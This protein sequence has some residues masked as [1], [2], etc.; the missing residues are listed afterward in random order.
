MAIWFV[1]IPMVETT[2]YVGQSDDEQGTH[3]GVS[4]HLGLDW[5]L[6]LA[7][8]TLELGLFLLDHGVARTSFRGLL[9]SR[10]TYLVE[11]RQLQWSRRGRWEEPRASHLVA[12]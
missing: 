2:L 8:R 10:R 4:S 1:C 3:L 7:P 12:R 6:H 9:S 11:N 5:Y